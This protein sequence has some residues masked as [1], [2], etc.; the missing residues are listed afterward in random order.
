MATAADLQDEL[1]EL[2]VSLNALERARYLSIASMCCLLYDYMLTFND[3][4]RVI[5]YARLKES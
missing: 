2:I 3:E 5:V 4:V 1:K